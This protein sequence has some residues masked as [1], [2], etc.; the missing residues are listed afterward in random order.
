[1]T[2]AAAHR[3]APA[4]GG[5]ESA[6]ARGRDAK[7]EWTRDGT[8]VTPEMFARARGVSV[9]DLRDWET[10][11]TLFSMVVDDAPYYLAELLMFAAADAA[12]VC[13]ALG[14]EDP[15]SKLIFFMRKHGMLGGK[16]VA[17]AIEG[18][19]LQAV[20]RA[21]ETWQERP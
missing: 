8:L 1:M 14:G 18:G 12:A 11:G 9:Q 2:G 20:L 10:I 19:G 6:L 5:F 7:R 3:V 16:T 13:L 4:T 15:A 21:A 17:Q